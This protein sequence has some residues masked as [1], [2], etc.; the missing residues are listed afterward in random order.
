MT[1]ADILAEYIQRKKE[2]FMGT[3]SPDVENECVFT[4]N[5]AV[6]SA[7]D[8]CIIDLNAWNRYHND[9]TDWGL[10]KTLVEIKA[11]PVLER[12]YREYIL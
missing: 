8:A 2:R 9:I 11:L 6:N 1:N 12:R 4:A 3:A 7:I 10:Q 5:E